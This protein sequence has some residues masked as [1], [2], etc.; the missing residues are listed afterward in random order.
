MSDRSQLNGLLGN[1][2]SSQ[3]SGKGDYQ[4]QKCHIKSA[5]WTC[6]GF[7]EILK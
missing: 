6:P 1:I 5:L 7:V 2:E 3:I 4:T